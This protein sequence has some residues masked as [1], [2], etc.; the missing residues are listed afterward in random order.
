M[1]SYAGISRPTNFWYQS[2]SSFSWSVVVLSQ[3]HNCNPKL[4]DVGYVHTSNPTLIFI[5]T[6]SPSVESYESNL[7]INVHITDIHPRNSI[8]QEKVN[9]LFWIVEWPTT[10]EM[11]T[12]TNWFMSAKMDVGGPHRQG[13]HIAIRLNLSIDPINLWI[14]HCGGAMEATSIFY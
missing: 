7:A 9:V 6:L 2:I 1:L 12:D 14:F 8:S 5:P 3:I 4:C 11:D 13:R 10:N